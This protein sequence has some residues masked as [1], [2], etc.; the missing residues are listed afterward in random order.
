MFSDLIIDITF[1]NIDDY[2]EFIDVAENLFIM[3]Y[4]NPIP[5]KYDMN[6]STSKQ[7]YWGSFS[8]INNVEICHK[9][10]KTMNINF[11]CYV[12]GTPPFIFMEYMKKLDF[13]DDFNMMYKIEEF[14][15][16]F[17]DYDF[18]R[19]THKN[20][21]QLFSQEYSISIEFD[22]TKVFPI[23]EVTDVIYKSIVNHTEQT[24]T[25]DEKD[26]SFILSYENYSR[27]IHLTIFDNKPF[28]QYRLNFKSN[29]LFDKTFW[30]FD[31]IL[32]IQDGL[33]N[34]VGTTINI[35]F[36]K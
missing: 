18:M 24:I 7:I 6:D 10:D 12:K 19:N 21:R 33:K 17:D 20:N 31:D 9:R 27:Y 34:L 4:Y 11:T 36:I 8:D 16:C 32:N 15:Y 13:I 25:K 22:T 28:K 30:T 5:D 2:N 23:N 26:N 14:T 1:N 3:N 35:T 29:E